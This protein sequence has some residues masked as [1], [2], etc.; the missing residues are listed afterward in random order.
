MGAYAPLLLYIA[1][2]LI[3]AQKVQFGTH[4]LTEEDDDW[5][6]NTRQRLEVAGNEITWVVFKGE[7]LERYFPED[8]CGKKEIEFL[9]LK[10][11]NS[12]VAEYAAKFEE[13]V[14]LCPHYNDAA[15]EVS[16][17]IKFEKGLRPEIKQSIGYQQIRWFP[18]LVNKCRIYDEDN[19]AWSDHYKSLGE[20]RGKQL[21]CEKLYIVPA[22]KGK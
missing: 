8:V 19:R 6:G 7:F 3:E 17:C 18:E 1:P 10:Q 15:V 22:D 2:S 12:S 5:W 20:K 11:W 9:E 13:L 14:K 21:N 4:M 16:K